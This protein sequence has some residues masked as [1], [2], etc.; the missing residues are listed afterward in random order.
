MPPARWIETFLEAKTA[1]EGLARNSQ[2]AYLR[3]LADFNTF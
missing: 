1:E 3:D 2:L